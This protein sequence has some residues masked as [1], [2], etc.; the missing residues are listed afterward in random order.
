MWMHTL[1]VWDAEGSTYTGR[2]LDESDTVVR[3][4]VTYPVTNPTNLGGEDLVKQ[5]AKKHLAGKIVATTMTSHALTRLMPTDESQ[6]AVACASVKRTL[7]EGTER[8]SRAEL[9]KKAKHY[10]DRSLKNRPKAPKKNPTDPFKRPPGAA[11]HSKVFPG[12]KMVWKGGKW[13]EPCPVRPLATEETP[14]EGG[15]TFEIEEEDTPVANPKVGAEE[16]ADE[17]VDGKKVDDDDDE[18]DDDDDEDDDEDDEDDD[19][20]DE[21]DDEDDDEDDED[22]E[23]LDRV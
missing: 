13:N 20:D 12:Q 21:E 1:T 17:G 16:E 7:P 3:N 10:V 19:D 4:G 22:E 2:W 14:K 11:P 8:P 18:D 6:D 23:E 15:K 9:V 5:N